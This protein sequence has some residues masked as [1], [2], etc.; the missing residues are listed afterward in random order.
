M[1]VTE[2]IPVVGS[3]AASG[4]RDREAGQ[5]VPP[6][7]GVPGHFG[8]RQIEMGQIDPGAAFNGGKPELDPRGP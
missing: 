5:E 4:S 1:F 7:V 3:G 6:A 2:R 8:L